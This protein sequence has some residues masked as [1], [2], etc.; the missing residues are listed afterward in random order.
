MG[1]KASLFRSPDQW[2]AEFES[3]GLKIG[4]AAGPFN[5]RKELA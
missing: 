3:L 4:S 5:G 2:T 1:W